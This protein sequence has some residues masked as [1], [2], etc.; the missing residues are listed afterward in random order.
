[1]KSCRR[2]ESCRRRRK[3]REIRLIPLLLIPLLLFLLPLSR[4]RPLPPLFR[5]RRLSWIAQCSMPFWPE[6]LP[7]KL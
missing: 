1:M 2:K 7:R 6:Q 5:P 3:S 4:I